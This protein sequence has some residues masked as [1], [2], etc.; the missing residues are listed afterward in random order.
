[1]SWRSARPGKPRWHRLLVA[2]WVMFLAS[3]VLPVSEP[4]PLLDTSLGWEAAL[5]AIYLGIEEQS[6]FALLSGLSNVLILA[7]FLKL[8]GSRPPTWRWLTWIISGAALLNLWWVFKAGAI[9]STAAQIAFA[10]IEGWGLGIGY[11][12]EPGIGYW[13]WIASFAC[14]AIALHLRDREL[15][16]RRLETEVA[17]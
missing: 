6:A 11:R 5:A 17:T 13:V 12:V 4:V 10:R 8:G 1:M 7:T 15:S 3:F 2:G 9:Q 14:V 16:P